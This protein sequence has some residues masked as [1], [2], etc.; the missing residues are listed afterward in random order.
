MASRPRTPE[1]RCDS[2]GPNGA[3]RLPERASSHFLYGPLDR[4]VV[5]VSTANAS[6]DYGMGYLAEH[7]ELAFVLQATSWSGA[8]FHKV[9]NVCAE[10][11]EPADLSESGKCQWCDIDEVDKE[12]ASRHSLLSRTLAHGIDEESLSV[13]PYGAKGTFDGRVEEAIGVQVR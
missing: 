5:N 4:E 9:A 10:C 12:E 7:R 1:T 3:I 11:G 2:S 8:D 6:L 13:R